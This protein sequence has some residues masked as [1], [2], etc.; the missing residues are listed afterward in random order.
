MVRKHLL[1]LVLALTSLAFGQT[2][3]K[4]YSNDKPGWWAASAQYPI[5]S[6]PSA[7]NSFANEHVK[8]TAVDAVDGFVKG[9][10]DFLI[11]GKKPDRPFVYEA[12]AFVTHR[13]P[14]LVSLFFDAY[15]EFGGPHPS[16]T[17]ICR[18]YALVGG[19]PKEMSLADLFNSG[20][21]GP[22]QISDYVLGKLR[23]KGISGANDMKELSKDDLG[24]FVIRA[25]AIEIRIAADDIGGYAEGPQVVTVPFKMLHGMLPIA[26][27]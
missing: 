25:N 7:L 24:C 3:T 4:K 27:Q 26:V 8:T 5:F 18:T 17:S 12:V 14:H 19:A 11:D 15:E 6:P 20:S 22:K 1:L 16:T 13:T 10:P 23:K 21:N 9:T 2:A